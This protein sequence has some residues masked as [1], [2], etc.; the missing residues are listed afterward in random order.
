MQALKQ[1]SI[2]LQGLKIGIHHF[3]FDVDDTF[4][5]SFSDSPIQQGTLVA[6]VEID[7]KIDHLILDLNISGTIKT[8]CDRC[9]AEIN[10]PVENIGRLIFKF[11]QDDSENTDE[12][13][14]YLKPDENNLNVSKYIY[15]Y[16]VLAI[17]FAKVYD[18]NLEAELPCDNTVLVHLSDS[19]IIDQEE[20]AAP[21]N[22]F[23]ELLKNLKLDKK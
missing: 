7:K 2:L 14:V 5:S 9:T 4:F 19:E 12:N 21:E 18:C 11:T 10:L 8:H 22:Q 20:E 13:V 15:E 6:Q 17:P 23:S 1:F 16:I 3:D